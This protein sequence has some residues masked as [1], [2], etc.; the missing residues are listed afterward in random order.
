ML[1]GPWK[2]IPLSPTML[3][4]HTST[5]IP[6]TIFTTH[7]PFHIPGIADNDTSC[8][9][10]RDPLL[11][12]ESSDG[13]CPVSDSLPVGEY[14]PGFYALSTFA[15]VFSPFPSGFVIG[16]SSIGPGALPV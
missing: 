1:P 15:D 12:G 14:Q 10:T 9:T 2:E 4:R 8:S 3:T 5:S 7:I 13:L 11:I 6:L 16:V